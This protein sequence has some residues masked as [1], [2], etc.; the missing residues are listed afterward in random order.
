MPRK[1]RQDRVAQTQEQG[2]T[3]WI[4][5][6]QD[7]RDVLTVGDSVLFGCLSPSSFVFPPY[8]RDFCHCYDKKIS[9]K[10]NLRK[11]VIFPYTTRVQCIRVRKGQLKEFEAAGHHA[12][13]RETTVVISLSSFCSIQD[14][15]IH[16]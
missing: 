13:S 16:G 5:E 2:K 15:S 8:T 14:Q 1:V 12:G 11:E 4:P 6:S 9:K 3:A 7:R 10:Y